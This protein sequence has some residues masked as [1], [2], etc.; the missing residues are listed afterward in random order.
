MVR[1]CGQSDDFACGPIALGNALKYFGL[2]R[3]F[4]KERKNLLKAVNCNRH[5]GGTQPDDFES[6]IRVLPYNW[7]VVLIRPTSKGAFDKLLSDGW[8]AIVRFTWAKWSTTH[9]AFFEPRQQIK[10]FNSWYSTANFWGGTTA[11]KFVSNEDVEKNLFK[12]THDELYVWFVK[13]R[14]YVD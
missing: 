9:Y 14:S 6:G 5:M 10:Y 2:L 1:Y 7:S 13:G 12:T 11:R 3:S 4:T 8:G